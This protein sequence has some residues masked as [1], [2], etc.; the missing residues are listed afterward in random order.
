MEKLADKLDNIYASGD[1]ADFIETVRLSLNHAEKMTKDGDEAGA[2][3]YLSDKLLV[4]KY[5]MVALERE[6]KK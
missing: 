1:A 4:W 5:L 2:V 3:R 6:T